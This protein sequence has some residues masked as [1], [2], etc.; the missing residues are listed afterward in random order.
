MSKSLLTASV[1]LAA[2]GLVGLTLGSEYLLN[3]YNL[4][5]SETKKIQLKFTSNENK[6][7]TLS[8]IVGFSLLGLGLY[9]NV[10]KT[11]Y[12]KIKY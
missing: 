3:W 11:L 5:K 6:S 12:Q 7:K 1:V 9:Y 8:S 10:P 4:E 2:G